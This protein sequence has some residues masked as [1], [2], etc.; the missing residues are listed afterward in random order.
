MNKFESGYR[1]EI[2]S[3]INLRRDDVDISALIALSIDEL[4]LMREHSA[5]IENSIF[6]K[7]CEFVKEWESQA[8]KTALFDKAL[9]YIDAPT[10]KH[11]ENKWKQD[12][13]YE[14][15]SNKV[16]KMYFRVYEHKEYNRET[17]KSEPV[18]WYVSW[19]LGT[20]SPE[21]SAYN[22]R[23]SGQE[24]KKF[25]D[26]AEADKYI[27]GRKSAYA[28]LFTELSP[29]IPKELIRCFTVNNQL[30]PGYTAQLE[31]EESEQKKC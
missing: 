3:T 15:I 20:N 25:T 21:K 1:L 5:E 31:D 10:T 9:E 4:Q 28:K 30:L 16:Y 27:V 22:Q 8:V 26:K 12:E 6:E 11:T 19:Y 13:C 18:S 7:L 2:E 17:A 29:P 14:E 23:I 24:R